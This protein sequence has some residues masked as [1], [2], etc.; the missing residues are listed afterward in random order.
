M[1]AFFTVIDGHG[2]CAATDHVTE[3][4]G[5]NIVRATGSVQRDGSDLY[6]LEQAIRGG[7]LVTDEEFL[8]KVH[9]A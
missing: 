3:N 6:D 8:R 2:G 7:Y 5:E 4:L 9:A 1:Q